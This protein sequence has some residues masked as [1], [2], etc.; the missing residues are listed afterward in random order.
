M[1]SEIK[2]G[3][4]TTL[5]KYTKMHQKSVRQIT[6]I[7]LLRLLVF[8][9]GV[10]LIYF[11]AQN[12]SYKAMVVSFVVSTFIF[13]T[14][15]KTHS[16]ILI[17]KKL[18]EAIIKINHDELLA[19]DGNFSAF[20]SGS[21]FVDPGHPYSY[22]LDIFGEG[23]LFQFLN[24]TST[25]TG[26]DNLASILKKPYLIPE[27]IKAN[28]VAIAE[29]KERR[30]WRQSFQS[31]GI[32]YQDNH[33]DKERIL[34]WV[35]HTPAFSHFIY[36]FILFFIPAVTFLMIILLS[37]NLIDTILFL[38]YIIIPLGI[39]GALANK[40]N[41]RHREVSKTTEMLKKYA[42]LLQK[43]EAFEVS[44]A[45]LIELK[46]NIIKNKN[47]AAK[48][49][50]TLSSIVSAL[51][52]RLNFVSWI[53]FNGL[54]LW[55]I[56][57][58]RRLETWQRTYKNEI[59]K[60][61]ETIAEMDALI[62]FSNFYDNHPDAAFPEILTDEN[63]VE[64]KEMGHPL[65]QRNIRVNNSLEIQE[66]QFL[67]ITGANMA[68][69]STYLRTV[70]VNL[71]LAMCGAPVCAKG[72]RFKPVN[73]YTSIHT[74]DSLQKNES[75]FYS[76]LKRLKLIIDELKNGAELFIILDEILKG[77]NSRDKH[78]GSEALLK[79]LLRFNARGIV[80]THDVALGLLEES[81]PDNIR[82]RCFEV[83]I[84]GS[85]LIFDYKL[86]DGVSK[87]MNATLLM[88]EMGITV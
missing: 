1:I 40:V 43:I 34:H 76:E 66:S 69:K 62:C 65:I 80:A 26:N 83:D 10:V 87:N 61:F 57:Q 44:S 25:K 7:S 60:W 73:I 53:L 59:G 68:G 46:L 55:D 3:Y 15:V 23:S 74:S 8:L 41:Y 58:M 24:R 6:T 42:L 50:K 72:F 78:T 32:V 56:L 29:L 13:I 16:K 30:I 79:Q 4:Q 47:S 18:R 88:K 31:I 12:G 81:F 52:N 82:N 11:F 5:D 21:E 64:A 45:K 35:K 2:A 71:I 51:D 9:A 22:D 84:E 75:Y 20:N 19:L 14:L 39:S 54:I 33:N 36:S 38:L 27:V 49:I 17:I 77:T 63:I 67:I 86:K 70:G 48:S 37:I 28:Q 85:R